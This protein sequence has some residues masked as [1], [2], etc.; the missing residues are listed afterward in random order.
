MISLRLCSYNIHKG[1]SSGNRQHVLA[2][3][4]EAIRS[5]DADLVCLQEVVGNALV[6]NGERCKLGNQFEY[7]ADQVWPHHAYGKNAVYTGGHHGNAILS[8]SPI[9]DSLNHDISVARFSQRGILQCHLSNGVYVFCLH[10]GLIGIERQMQLA[11]LIR[12]IDRE[13]PPHAPMIIAGDFNDWTLR[14]DR[15]LKRRFGLEEVH[16]LFHRRPARSFPVSFPLLPM[17][18][19]YYRN[20][21]CKTV[22]LLRGQPWSR[23]SDHCPLYCELIAS[24]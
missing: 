7:L 24:P 9:L 2:D 18:R 3:I 21:K 11:R 16:S 6:K 22:E 4:R 19:I 8:K 13:V 5:I 12:I 14:I 17:D 20:L 15:A 1:M 23:M 10:L